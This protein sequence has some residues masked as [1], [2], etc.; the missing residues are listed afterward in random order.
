MRLVFI[1]VEL[2]QDH[3][4]ELRRIRR[5]STSH[6]SQTAT[7]SNTRGKWLA[8]GWKES[9]ELKRLACKVCRKLNSDSRDMSQLCP[10]NRCVPSGL[11]ELSKLTRSAPLRSAP[12][13]QL[14]TNQWPLASV[15]RWQLYSDASE[16]YFR[17]R[18][19]LQSVQRSIG[20]RGAR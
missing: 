11:R 8:I 7:T 6:R 13:A 20:L 4:R 3:V 2:A 14:R 18:F 15:C 5:N 17:I 16:L 9:Q 1:C 12:R 19:E 10:I